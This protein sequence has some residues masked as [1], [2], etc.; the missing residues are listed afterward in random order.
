M[1]MIVKLKELVEILNQY[2]DEDSENSECAACRLFDAMF[3]DN[4]D[5]LLDHT[6]IIHPR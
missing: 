4:C 2:D 1:S 3:D 6:L 5:I